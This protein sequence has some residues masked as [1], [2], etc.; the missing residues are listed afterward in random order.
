MR[1]RKLFIAC[2]EILEVDRVKQSEKLQDSSTEYDALYNSVKDKIQNDKAEEEENPPADEPSP[3]TST[4]PDAEPD[5]S[6]G[7]DTKP[8]E[9]TQDKPEPDD[10]P[11]EEPKPED[12][13]PDVDVS[14]TKAMESILNEHIL[15]YRT[16][17]A[18]EQYA[19]EGSVTDAAINVGEHGLQALK[20]GAGYLKEL[21]AEYGPIL[22]KHVYKGVISA[23]ARTAKALVRGGEII[24]KYVKNRMQSYEAIK[25][26]VG[27]LRQTLELLQNNESSSTD[28]QSAEEKEPLYFR[29]DVVIGSLK[30]GES[31]DFGKNLLVAKDMMEGYYG[32]LSKKVSDTVRSTHHLIDG[33]MKASVTLPKAVMT[34]DVTGIQ[35]L[36]PKQLASYPTE[37]DALASYVYKNVL[38][39]DLIFIMFAPRKDLS[40]EADIKSA[41]A[42]SKTLIGLSEKT[43]AVPDFAPM[44]TKEQIESAL[45]TIEEI[46][47][48][49]LSHRALF[50][51]I[52]KQR[53]SLEGMLKSYLNFLATSKDK[54]SIKQSMSEYVSLKLSF[55]DKV[56]VSGAFLLGD[57]MTR[58]LT[59]SLT[60]YKDSLSA[61]V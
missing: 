14:D 55:L 34:D 52:V 16:M 7:E 20:A 17:L 32:S 24:A 6:P 57:Y 33:V 15:S 5:P 27:K 4:E 22:L 47:D 53:Q 44:A 36:T 43:A 30:I 50:E 3:D 41:Y 10:P 11:K 21:G 49:G 51:S 35:G 40:S 29:K 56:Y 23:L 61:K 59:N 8:T 54:I 28:P 60:Y 37:N 12:D 42:N 31:L 38:P 25:A 19:M 18:Q 9:D 39:G 13:K 58:L 45:S 46:C 26:K 1:G 2:E 48:L